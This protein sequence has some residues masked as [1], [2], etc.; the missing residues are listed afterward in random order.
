MRGWIVGLG[1][2]TVGAVGCASS[3]KLENQARIHTLRADAAAQ[4]RNYDLA[5]REKAEAERLHEKAVARAYKEGRSSEVVVP[6]DVPT[7]PIR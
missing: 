2:V 3:T 6:A 1:L 5:A 4:T 7:A